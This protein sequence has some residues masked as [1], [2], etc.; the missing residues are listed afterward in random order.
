MSESPQQV[1]C[2]VPLGCCGC[3]CLGLLAVLGLGL[4]GAG[5]LVWNGIRASG[6][7]RTYQLAVEQL[8]QNAVVVEQLG[9]PLRP[10][11]PSRLRFQEDEQAG[12]ACL[13]FLITG[14]RRTGEV[15]VESERGVAGKDSVP[16][17]RTAWQLRHLQVKVDGDPQ[18]IRVIEGGSRCEGE[19]PPLQAEGEI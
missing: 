9:D 13:S 5:I 3:G 19:E 10:G 18:A 14:S 8:E 11:W 17:T 12:W 15:A 2:A 7:Y 6:A 4:V 16:L 1:G